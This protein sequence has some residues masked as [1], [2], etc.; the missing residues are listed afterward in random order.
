MNLVG[1]HKYNWDECDGEFH[2]YY[3]YQM[4]SCP[5]CEKV[6]FL[7]QYW[8]SLLSEQNDN[9][10]AKPQE[11]ILY[12]ANKFHGDYVPQ[13]VKDA[14]EAALK[15]KN[16]DSSICLIALR[17]TLEI[18]CKEKKAKGRNLWTK[19]TD[20]S[21]KGILPLELKNASTI[22]KNYGNIGAHGEDLCISPPELELNVNFVQYIIDYLYILP[23]KIDEAQ[24]KL[25]AVKSNNNLESDKKK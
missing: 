19:I 9:Y 13:N 4:F 2:G 5:I 17:R 12:P 18:I 8:D 20:L 25:E 15:T 21:K 24:K 11:E 6:T 1:E 14:Y 22:T 16:I 23:A 7:E 10:S 3:N